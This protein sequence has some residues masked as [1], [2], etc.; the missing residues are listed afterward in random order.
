MQ[1]MPVAVKEV[2]KEE[3]IIRNVYDPKQ[4]IE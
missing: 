2:N 1:L 4:N 3:T